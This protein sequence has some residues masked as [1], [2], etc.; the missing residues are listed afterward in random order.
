MR[1]INCWSVVLITTVMLTK[2]IVKLCYPHLWSDDKRII[3]DEVHVPDRK[4]IWSDQNERTRGRRAFKIAHERLDIGKYEGIIVLKD[5]STSNEHSK[6]T[7][8]NLWST[9]V[10]V[11]TQIELWSDRLDR[12]PLCSQ[13]EITGSGQQFERKIVWAMVRFR[14]DQ[15]SLQSG[16]S[17]HRSF[18]SG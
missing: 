10:E 1:F 2:L 3:P 11:Q 13:T 18:Q 6:Q 16:R 15:R 9:Q 4:S 7:I 14:S 5:D 8:P 12:T 17:D